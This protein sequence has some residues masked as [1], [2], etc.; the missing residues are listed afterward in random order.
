MVRSDVQNPDDPDGEHFFRRRTEY[1][2]NDHLSFMRFLGLDLSDR[3]PDA[4]TIRL[5]RELLTQAGAIERLFERFN[6]T[7]Q[8]AG[9]LPMSGQILNATLV[10]PPPPPQDWQ[11]KPAKLSRKDHHARWALKFAKAKRHVKSQ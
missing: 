10:T 2:L 8:N 3:V 11:D 5:F 4:K 1:L 6:A 9:Y 7:L